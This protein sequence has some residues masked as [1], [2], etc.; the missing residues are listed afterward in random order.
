MEQERILCKVKPVSKLIG[1]INDRGYLPVYSDLLNYYS[2][3]P[4][5]SYEKSLLLSEVIIIDDPELQDEHY[6]KGVT[7][8]ISNLGIFHEDRSYN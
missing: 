5:L 6:V 3:V 2:Y 4:R 1:L 7:Q 8:S